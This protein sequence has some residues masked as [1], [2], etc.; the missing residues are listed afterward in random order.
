MPQIL[1]YTRTITTLDISQT[2]L[3]FLNVDRRLT[4]EL[5][6]SSTYYWKVGFVQRIYKATG[7]S[8]S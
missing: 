8:P 2:N 7:D 6:F 1:V 5:V 4:P 3:L